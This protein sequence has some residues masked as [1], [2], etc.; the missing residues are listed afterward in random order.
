[1]LPD[2]EA[3]RSRRTRR[4]RGSTSDVRAVIDGVRAMRS[5]R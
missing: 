1:M 3:P 2:T 4:S 5:A